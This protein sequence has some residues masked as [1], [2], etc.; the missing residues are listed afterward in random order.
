MVWQVN[1]KLA[2]KTYFRNMCRSLMVRDVV[3]GSGG[4]ILRW[5]LRGGP[6]LQ[7]RNFGVRARSGC[8]WCPDPGIKVLELKFRGPCPGPEVCGP[9]RESPGPCKDAEAPRRSSLGGQLQAMQASPQ[10]LQ[11]GE[12]RQHTRR[13]W[14]TSRSHRRVGFPA[15]DKGFGL[16]EGVCARRPR[17]RRTPHP[18]S[19]FSV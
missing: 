14:E 3:P 16:I 5:V 2:C 19:K 10:Q 7:I 1:T 17:S 4:S 15:P 11:P 6:K 12:P 9:K 13:S 18:K 8:V